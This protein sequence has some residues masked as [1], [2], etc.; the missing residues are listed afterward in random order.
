MTTTTPAVLRDPTIGFRRAVSAFALPLGF[1]AQVVAN[2]AYSIATSAGGSDTDGAAALEL[3]GREPGL[4]T[5]ATV[6]AMLGSFLIVAGA[7]AALRVV[8][9]RAPRLGLVAAIV[10]GAGYL[11]YIGIVADGF[12]TVALAESGLDA[13]A[14]LDAADAAPAGVWV[15]PVFVLGNM[16]GALLLG[17]AVIRSREV[18]WPVG[19]AIALWMPAHIA[20]LVVG[21]EWIQVAGGTIQTVGCLVLALRAVRIPDAEWVARG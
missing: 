2:T 10:L 12:L 17:I 14:A 5:L 6:A 4:L 20:G 15:F 1:A 8:R 7:P 18:P 11:C 16:L 19:A 9:P 3:Y 13:A 21:T